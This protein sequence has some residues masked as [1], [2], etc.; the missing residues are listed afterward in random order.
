MPTLS[1][2]LWF[3]NSSVIEEVKIDPDLD[4]SPGNVKY[5]NRSDLGNQVTTMSMN[6]VDGDGN[7]SR[8]IN[9]STAKLLW[10]KHSDKPPAWIVGT[11]ELLVALLADHYGCPVGRPKSWKVG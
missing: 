7:W 6:E 9:S 10:S 1:A 4:A 3:G 2:T 11:D 8:E 5:L